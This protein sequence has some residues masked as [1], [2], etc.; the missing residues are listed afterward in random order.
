MDIVNKTINRMKFGWSKYGGAN[1][2]IIVD[3]DETWACQACSD[4]SN[5]V[6]PS[7]LVEFEDT[8]TLKICAKCRNVVKN[9]KLVN[10]QV[11]IKIVRN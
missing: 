3:H 9:E 10:F 8:P 11:L 2:E 7:F 6:I 4:M 5:K 1:R